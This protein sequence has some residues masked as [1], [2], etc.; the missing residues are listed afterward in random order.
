MFLDAQ[1][2]EYYT[3]LQSIHRRLSSMQNIYVLFAKHKN[4]N[5]P[6]VVDSLH[7]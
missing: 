3:D 2:R 4:T 1:T 7:V 5:Q 6:L